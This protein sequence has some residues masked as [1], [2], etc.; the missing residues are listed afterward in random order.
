MTHERERISNYWCITAQSYW[1]YIRKHIL[2]VLIIDLT[3]GNYIY[4]HEAIELLNIWE[5]L[6]NNETISKFNKNS[7]ASSVTDF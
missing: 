4:S 2:D 1:E 6:G 3:L 5:I 7:L